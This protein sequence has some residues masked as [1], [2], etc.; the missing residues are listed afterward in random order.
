MLDQAEQNIVWLNWATPNN[1]FLQMFHKQ[2]DNASKKTPF[3]ISKEP[4]IMLWT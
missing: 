4:W 1:F 2:S 3:G